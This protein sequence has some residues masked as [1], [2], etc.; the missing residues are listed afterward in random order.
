MP[1]RAGGAVL[2]KIYPL[3]VRNQRMQGRL[4]DALLA[5]IEQH[6]LAGGQVLLYLN[7]RGYAPNLLCHACGWVVGCPHCDSFVTWHRRG[8]AAYGAIIA[9]LNKPCQRAARVVRR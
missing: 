4:S 6:L 5:A 3:D 2:P 1:E 7:R 8:A 9:G